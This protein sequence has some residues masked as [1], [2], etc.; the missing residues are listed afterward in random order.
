MLYVLAK[1]TDK[2]TLVFSLSDSKRTFYKSLSNA[3]QIINSISVST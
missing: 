3:S 2:D 1:T